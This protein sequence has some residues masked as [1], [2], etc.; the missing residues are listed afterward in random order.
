MGGP[1]VSIVLMVLFLALTQAGGLWA[2][3]GGIGF[4]INLMT[5]VY[6]L[7]PIGTMDGLAVWKWNRALYLMLFLPMIA[8]YF[9]TYM[10]G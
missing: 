3:A 6:S 4:S 8:F 10:T 7:M 5:A 9:F 1:C 2:I